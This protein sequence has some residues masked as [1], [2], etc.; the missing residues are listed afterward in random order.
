MHKTGW[1][2][3]LA[4]LLALWVSSTATVTAAQIDFEDLA[5]LDS[6][7]N[8]YPGVLFT[9]ATVLTAG[10]SL[11]E[12]EFPPHSGGNV[13]I[14]DGGALRLTFTKPVKAFSAYFTYA[15]PL[16]ITAF[17]ALNQQITVDNSAYANNLALSGDTGSV[18][19]ELLSLAASRIASIRITGADAGFSFAL[20]D[21]TFELADTIVVPEPAT[22]GLLLVALLWLTGRQQWRKGF[23]GY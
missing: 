4:G 23:Y 21:I 5:D 22:L 3:A 20:D 10:I 6:V 7:T 13:V 11:N 18:P 15:A 2:A 12:F 1:T 17:D 16:I 14:D 8:H 19:N 9:N